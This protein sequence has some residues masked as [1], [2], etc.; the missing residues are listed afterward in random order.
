MGRMGIK[1]LKNGV[2]SG[3]QGAKY[4]KNTIFEWRI[5]CESA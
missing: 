3:F 5:S 4:T 1:K 2:F